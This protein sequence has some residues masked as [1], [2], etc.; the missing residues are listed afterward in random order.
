MFGTSVAVR[1]FLLC[2]FIVQTATKH[3]ETH[4]KASPTLCWQSQ[5]CL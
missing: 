1:A 4:A 3:G 5:I 2:K